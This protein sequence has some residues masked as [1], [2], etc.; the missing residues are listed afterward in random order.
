MSTFSLSSSAPDIHIETVNGEKLSLLPFFEKNRIVL[1][2]IPADYETEGNGYLKH[3]SQ[4]EPNLTKRDLKILV[5]AAAESPLQKESFGSLITVVSKCDPMPTSM[6][7]NSDTGPLFILIDKD[8]SITLREQKFVSEKALFATI[9]AT[10]MRRS[11][12]KTK[13]AR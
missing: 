6:S 13:T 4:E 9:D 1:L 7:P 11:E 3:L 5:V 10:P 2:F 8:R 12:I